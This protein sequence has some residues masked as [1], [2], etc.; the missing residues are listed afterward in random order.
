[1][2]RYS[3]TENRDVHIR[4]NDAL[5][6]GYNEDAEKRD[7]FPKE[8]DPDYLVPS[9]EV[10]QQLEML[11]AP[12]EPLQFSKE[13]RPL[14]LPEVL[15]PLQFPEVLQPL[16]LPEVL[17]PHQL[18]EVLSTLQSPEVLQPLPLPE[19]MQ[20]LQ[21][22][23]A[24]LQQLEMSTTSFS[25]LDLPCVPLMEIFGKL[26]IRQRLRTECVSKGWQLFVRASLRAEREFHF[27]WE[28]E[29]SSF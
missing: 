25:L 9:T 17:Q 2:E 26:T 14:Q 3:C 7:E 23:E 8:D 22:P 11:G 20:P 1:M 16:Q 18:P 28:S 12:V 10:L 29:G 6:T 24:P 13:L 19:V 5:L 4:S 27:Y 21:L 15:Q